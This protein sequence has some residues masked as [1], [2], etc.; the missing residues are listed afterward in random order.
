MEQSLLVKRLKSSFWYRL[1]LF[2]SLPAAFFSGIYLSTLT[3]E[4][5]VVSIRYSWFSKNPF[6]SI[7]FACLAM[8]AEMSSGVLA[9]VHSQ[10][11]SPS[12]SMLVLGM[13]SEF[14]KKAIGKIRFECND[15]EMIKK[16]IVEAIQ[17]KAGVTCNTLSS[18]FDEKGDCIAEFN[19]TWSF[20]QKNN[21]L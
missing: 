10:H 16:A 19:I 11:M 17:T 14:H 6:R 1:F 7:Y 8:A 9:L 13:K 15:G 4:K 18:G 20:K 2:T 21:Q 5:S 3:H 12:V